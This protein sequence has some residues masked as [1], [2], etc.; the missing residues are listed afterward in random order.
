MGQGP[1]LPKAEQGGAGGM[2]PDNPTFI[3]IYLLS[4]PFAFL[5]SANDIIR[6]GSFYFGKSGSF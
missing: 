3:F 5:K 2:P 1:H 6:S 4:W